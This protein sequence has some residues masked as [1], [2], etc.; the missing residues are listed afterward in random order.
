M[1]MSIDYDFLDGGYEKH[2]PDAI[3]LY[4]SVPLPYI[5]NRPQ[6]LYTL[7]LEY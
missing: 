5:L 3:T 6:A 1:Y 2:R 4:I 7:S